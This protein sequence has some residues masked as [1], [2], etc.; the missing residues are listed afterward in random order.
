MRHGFNRFLDGRRFV[1]P[2]F[3]SKLRNTMDGSVL[4]IVVSTEEALEVLTPTSK[5]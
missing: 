5:N 2:L 4:H 3:E 1:K